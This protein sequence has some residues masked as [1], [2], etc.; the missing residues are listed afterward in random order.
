MPA[1]YRFPDA[2]R[3]VATLLI[4]YASAQRVG[5]R[6]PSSLTGL[7]PFIR[8]VRHGGPSDLVSDYARLHIDVLADSVTVGELLAE[9]IRQYL[10]TERL[11]LPPAIIDRVICD[12]APEEVAPWAPGIFRFEG[13]YTAVSRRYKSSA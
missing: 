6:V 1:T 13:R 3:T 7:L 10:T 12:G 4:P 11:S 5:T 8:V 2:A 9:R